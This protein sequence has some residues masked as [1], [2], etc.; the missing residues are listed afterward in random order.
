LIYLLTK[1]IWNWWAVDLFRHDSITCLLSGRPDERSTSFN[2]TAR[3]HNLIYNS[4]TILRGFGIKS[5]I[6]IGIFKPDG[7]CPQRGIL[8]PV[9]RTNRDAM[10]K[11]QVNSDSNLQAS[12][13]NC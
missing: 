12:E 11:S 7:S 9:S 6:N 3:S 5:P 8:L 4:W 10:L 1:L 2:P 13:L